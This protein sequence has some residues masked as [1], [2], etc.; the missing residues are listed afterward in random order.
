VSPATRRIAGLNR[1]EAHNR[2]RKKDDAIPSSQSTSLHS[3][4]SPHLDK[5]HDTLVDL[6]EERERHTQTAVS[7]RLA[8]LEATG[9]TTTSVTSMTISSC[10]VLYNDEIAEAISPS[11]AITDPPIEHGRAWDF[12]CHIK[13]GNGLFVKSALLADTG[14]S[15]W[16]FVSQK[17][18]KMHKLPTV[19]LSRPCN[20]KLADGRLVQQVTKAAEVTIRIGE[21]HY[22]TGWAIV[23][24]LKD[25]DIIHGMPWFEQH[26]PTAGWKN[27]TLTLDSEHCI[28]HCIHDKKPFMMKSRSNTSKMS[29]PS[30]DAT[31]Q[32]HDICAVSAEAFVKMAMRGDHEV[33]V[34]NPE[35]FAELSA[36]SS[37]DYKAFMSKMLKEHPSQ[38]EVKKLVRPEYHDYLDRW[39]YKAADKTPPRRPGVDHE[40]LL[41]PGAVPQA[42]AYISATRQHAQIVKAYIDDMIAKG[43]IRPS[44]SAW[45]APVIVVKKPGGGLRICVDYRAL[46]ALTIKNRNAP[47]LIRETLSRL[48]KAKWYTKFDII[49]AFNE[50]R[51]KEGHEHMTAFL[52]RYG[53]FEY[54]VVPFGLTNAPAT[55]QQYINHVLH[56]FLDRFCTAYLDDILI[57]SD[58][59]EE[60]IQHVT[61]V[62]AALREANLFLDIKKC[63]FHVKQVKYLGLVITTEGIKMDEEKVDA[64]R[65]WPQ[66]RNLKDVQAFLGF[67]NF[68]RRFITG[69]SSIVRAL[70]ALTSSE[71]KGFSYPWAPNS[72]EEL[73]FQ[74]IKSLFSTAGFLAHFDPDKET[75]V[76][77]DASDYVTAAVLSQ[78]D[79]H[80]VLRPIAFLS[81][82]MTPA[83]CN[84]EIYDKELLAIVRA[85]E[86][87]RPELSGTKE[88]VQVLSDHK[89]LE[90]F[91]TT[92]QLNRRQARWAEFLSEFNFRITY[93][94]GTEGTK[95][96]SMTRRSDDLPNPMDESDPRNQHQRQVVL[97]THQVDDKITRVLMTKGRPHDGSSYAA[98]IASVM[99]NDIHSNL[100]TLAS[101]I[102][103]EAE[104]VQPVKGEVTTRT[105]R[106]ETA[107]L[108]AIKEGTASA[109]TIDVPLSPNTSRPINE[110]LEDVRV[111]YAQDKD[112]QAIIHALEVGD[113]RIPMELIKKGYRIEIKDCTII[114]GMVYIGNRLLVPNQETL[115]AQLLK[116]VH[117]SPVGG[118]AGRSTTFARISDWYYWPGMTDTVARFVQAC[119][120]CKRAKPFRKAKHGLL[121]PLPIPDRYWKDISVDF[122]GPLPKC[123]FEGVVYEYIM[124]VVDRLSKLRKFIPLQNL[125]TEHVVNSFFHWVWRNEGFPDTV[126]SDRG[127]QF[128][129]HFWQRLCQRIGAQPRLSTS[130]HP[131]S[132]GQTEIANAGLKQ[133][134]RCYVGFNQDDW[135]SYLP[136]AEFEANLA[137]NESTTVSPFEATKGYLPKSGFEPPAAMGQ[138]LSAKQKTET[139]MADAVATRIQAL[140]GKLKE[141][142]RWAQALMKLHADK[143]RLPAPL[144]K[145]GDRVMLDS[146]YIKTSRP[147]E[148]LDDE[149]M[150]PFTILKIINDHSY[151]LD[152]PPSMKLFPV[153][154]PWLLHLHE[155]QP[156]EGQEEIPQGPVNVEEPDE[157]KKEY[158][159][160]EIVDSRIHKGRKDVLTGQKG[161]LEY[162]AKYPGWPDWNAN[163][164]WQPYWDFD[165]DDLVAD[166]HHRYRS[167]AGPHESFK[168]RTNW[169]PDGD[170]AANL[171]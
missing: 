166:F 61:Q 22:E 141:Q 12:E 165:C 151:L 74:Q 133:Y 163:P 118:H 71:S 67:C 82:K 138:G 167:K 62:L 96:D 21:S 33:M 150:G 155:V 68:Y 4:T 50:I 168:A 149:N 7:T 37:E 123:T 164:P 18:V 80:G 27:R 113:R 154:H 81:T 15:E 53:L 106:L 144:L 45:A 90:Y 20:L 49:A 110:I 130:H 3:K 73:A 103:S 147:S 83:E 108:T 56:D 30:M 63:E 23:T 171:V 70:T 129:S 128:V 11:S 66:P 31:C 42:K 28:S 112:M 98:H 136:T 25:Y 35:D 51:I 143:K 126:V 132:D 116:T 39:D 120:T 48:F 40:I 114:D 89:N 140:S 159:V 101:L 26:E 91:M 111:E 6:G 84:Y 76:E 60:H 92:K 107:R 13:A 32:E 94:P 127:R 5:A 109:K 1:F 162:K 75:W 105:L 24:D 119:N 148:S 88:P 17:F 158:F 46:N 153:F 78:L 100:T 43:F 8:Q 34:I 169:T 97:K 146:R 104:T 170:V 52:T 122:V 160:S 9:N 121:Q 95:P 134:L 47:P 137:V 157:E 57:Y 124:V 29:S 93:R 131:E 14:A 117:S 145:P 69:Y 99:F 64:I 72:A 156:L 87:W 102:Y 58:N 85:F 10:C 44:K 38:E 125:S 59:E 79:D 41:Q 36:I 142:L 77:T 55:W 139:A 135:V 86:E 65:N 54:N 161:R 19:E 152:L 2:H 115:Q 16:G